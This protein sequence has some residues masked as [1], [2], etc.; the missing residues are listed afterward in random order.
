MPGNH[1]E[2]PGR[3]YSSF[4]AIHGG[5]RFSF[6][7][8]GCRFVG[9]NNSERLMPLSGG[10]LDYLRSELS[11]P[12]AGRKFV[13]MHVPPRYREEALSSARLRGFR[14][15]ASDFRRTM[16]DHG[17]DQAFF[18]HIHGF[19]SA[20]IDGVRHTITAGAGAPLSSDLGPEGGVFNFVLV[21]VGPGGVRTE[22]FRLVD[23]RWVRSELT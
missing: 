23:G 19:A 20:R 10:D 13:L 4:E 3:D 9:I 17:V 18:G 22:V 7:Y 21:H 5:V 15:N 14:W 1:D 6:E 12:A 16:K 2:G 11:K 8:G